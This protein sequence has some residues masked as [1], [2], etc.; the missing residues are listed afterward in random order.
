MPKKKKLDKI[1]Q[2][3]KTK[4]APLVQVDPMELGDHRLDPKESVAREREALLD[5]VSKKQIAGQKE[6]EDFERSRG[7]RLQFTEIIGRLK[8]EITDL[9]VLEGSPG[10]VALY[11]PRDGADREATRN[12]I[13]WMNPPKDIGFF[14]HFKYVG[15]MPKTE[16]PEYGSVDI[17]TSGLPTREGW[18]EGGRFIQGH[19]W[20]T[21]LIMLMKAGAISY[22]ACVEQ[23]GD[24]G[25]DKRGWRWREQTAPWRNNPDEKFR[26]EASFDEE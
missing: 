10:N 16:I 21:T 13:D 5:K 14:V 7:N 17:D 26:H 1:D 24:V 3:V 22:N 18:M 11:F 12:E 23:F 2:M 25:T 15:G 9:K 4:T 6:L 19:S 20:R 8:R